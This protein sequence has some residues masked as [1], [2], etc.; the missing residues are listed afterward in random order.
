MIHL[1]LKR[2]ISK[3]VVLADPNLERLEHLSA[4]LPIMND[5]MVRI[6]SSLT[7]SSV[8]FVKP[9]QDW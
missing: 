7:M 8:D 2:I 4:N 3:I 5:M 1:K 6:S 9:K